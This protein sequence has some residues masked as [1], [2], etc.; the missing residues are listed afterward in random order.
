[1]KAQYLFVF[2][3]GL[4]LLFILFVI[5]YMAGISQWACIAFGTVSATLLV[6]LTFRL[7]GK[8]GEHGLMKLGAAR[9]HPRYL[10]NRRRISRL[11]KRNFTKKKGLL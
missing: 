6:W 2:A 11:F 4:L 7:N 1:M 5:M 9:S 8:Y 3:A 10:I